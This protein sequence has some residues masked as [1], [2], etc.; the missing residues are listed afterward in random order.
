MIAIHGSQLLIAFYLDW[1][2]GLAV[3]GVILLDYILFQRSIESYK[4]K[5]MKAIQEQKKQES[6]S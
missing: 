2:L 3:A 1:R 4:E 6:D 5:L